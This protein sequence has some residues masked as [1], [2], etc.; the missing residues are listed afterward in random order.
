MQEPSTVNLEKHHK[1]IVGTLNRDHFQEEEPKMKRNVFRVHTTKM[2][3]QQIHLNVSHALLA[4]AV[5]MREWPLP[6]TVQW[7]RSSAN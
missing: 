4:R 7:A 3:Q 1:Y 2:Q 5:P 6:P